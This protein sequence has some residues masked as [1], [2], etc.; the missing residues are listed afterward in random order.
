MRKPSLTVDTFVAALAVASATSGCSKAERASAAPEP[1]A[2]AV[3]SP[4]ADPAPVT[5]APQAAA[6]SAPAPESAPSTTSPE[7]PAK[8]AKPSKSAVTATPVDAGSASDKR[9]ADPMTCGAG[10]CTA[11]MKKGN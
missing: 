1:A 11:D 2:T 9:K 4:A 10:G 7:R 6:A 8:D 3:V 5:P